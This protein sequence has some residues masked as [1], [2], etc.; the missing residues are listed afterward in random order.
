MEVNNTTNNF[1]T[2]LTDKSVT[3]DKPVITQKPVESISDKMKSYQDEDKASKRSA[4]DF[5]QQEREDLVKDLNKE[6][7]LLSTDLKFGFNTQAE[8]LEISV[9]NTNT[10]KVI[11]RFP[12]EEAVKLQTAMKEFLGFLFD[13]RG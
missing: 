6:I 11:R 12:T 10:N 3:I 5:T 4:A 13:T 1:Y 7:G 8:T 9:I 2:D